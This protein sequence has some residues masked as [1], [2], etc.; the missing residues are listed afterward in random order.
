MNLAITEKVYAKPVA[1][2]FEIFEDRNHLVQIGPYTILHD[3]LSML[4]LYQ[5]HFE[6]TKC[7][8]KTSVRSTYKMLMIERNK[9]QE[10]I[11]RRIAATN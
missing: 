5:Q 6:V 4:E 10:E 3:C 1:E 8:R 9:L 7:L 11:E 2:S